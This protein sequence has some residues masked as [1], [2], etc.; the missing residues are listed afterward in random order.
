MTYRSVRTHV[1][2]DSVD[3]KEREREVSLLRGDNVVPE[4][5]KPEV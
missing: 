1:V 3:S 5:G 4:N 2:P